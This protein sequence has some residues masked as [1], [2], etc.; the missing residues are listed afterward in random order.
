MRVAL[1]FPGQGSEEPGMGLALATHDARAARWLAL[2]SDVL[3]LDV[4]RLLERGGKALARTEVL[5][6]VLAAV[7]LAA[8]ELAV[9]RGLEPTYVT[10][11]S[12]GELTAACFAARIDA[13]AA[14][15]LAAYRGAQMAREAEARPGGMTALGAAPDD[16]EPHVRAIGGTLSVAAINAPDETVVS[17]SVEELDALQA[18]LGARATRLRVAGPWH[19]TR[20][21][22][23]VE[24]FRARIREVLGARPLERFVASSLAMEAH[25]PGVLA[26]ALGRPV[27]FVET[28]ALLEARGVTRIA[29]AA[30]SRVVRSLVRRTLGT[31]VELIGVDTPRDLENNV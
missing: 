9:E 22:G 28:L 25:D 12:L 2:A 19:S 29:V 17:G 26:D 13:R 10:G 21:E 8:A 23:A 30:P 24:P 27:R 15:E 4:P 20:M 6:P 11:H 18:R 7:G 16:V 3:G 31:R 14:L 1:V 5:Q